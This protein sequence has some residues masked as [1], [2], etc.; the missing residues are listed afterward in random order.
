MLSQD[1]NLGESAFNCDRMFDMEIFSR[2]VLSAP[3]TH[4]HFND[5]Y[6]IR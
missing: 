5:R 2:R 6:M 3:Q 1:R 4:R